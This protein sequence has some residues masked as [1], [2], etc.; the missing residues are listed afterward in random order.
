MV[1][2]YHFPS[3]SKPEIIDDFDGKIA[4]GEGEN[5]TIIEG[6]ALPRT[7]Q[8]CNLIAGEFLLGQFELKQVGPALLIRESGLNPFPDNRLEITIKNFPFYSGGFSISLNKERSDKMNS[9]VKYSDPELFN[10]SLFASDD[11]R[12]RFFAP[13]KIT[14]NNSQNYALKYYDAHGFCLGVELLTNFVS[15]ISETPSNSNPN[16][17]YYLNNNLTTY[18]LDNG[19][20]A[21]IYSVDR[22]FNGENNNVISQNSISFLAIISENGVI[23]SNNKVSENFTR[24][25]PSRIAKDSDGNYFA[26]FSKNNEKFICQF[27]DPNNGNFLSD[28]FETESLED[29]TNI[30][31][32]NDSITLKTGH[33]IEA[34]VNN[35][36]KIC[37]KVCFAKLRFSDSCSSK[38]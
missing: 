18:R 28:I 11:I 35:S 20:I 2:L 5:L 13:G 15:K 23:I 7:D 4:I 29:L 26:C 38:F 27:F 12:G 19:N 14:V 16:I 17:N 1:K 3:L 25:S 36:F 32:H 24:T 6:K 30:I 8:N 22:E 10:R 33:K 37:R 31:E 21:F 34:D 9:A